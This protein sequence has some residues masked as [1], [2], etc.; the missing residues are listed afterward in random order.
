MGLLPPGRVAGIFVGAPD[1]MHRL[2]YHLL[3][4]FL[5]LLSACQGYDVKVNDTVVYRPEPLFSDF[6]VADDALYNCLR[7][8]IVDNGVRAPEQLEALNCSH[9]GILDLAGLATFSGIRALRLSSNRI[10]NLV[11]IGSLTGL[12][13][14]YLEDNAIV[15]PV[16]LYKLDGLR[17]LDLSGNTALQC[18]RGSGFARIETVILPDHCS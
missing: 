6:E 18:P 7:Q 3:G 10:R 13:E 11:E 2:H 1:I 5:L 12:E 8:A 15:D 14:L 4:L 17:H 9:A 16:P